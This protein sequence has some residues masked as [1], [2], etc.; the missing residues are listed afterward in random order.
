MGNSGELSV[1][2][3]DGTIATRTIQQVSSRVV[4][5]STPFTTLPA[6]GSIWVIETPDILT[7]TW[8]VVSITEGDQG[9]F[10]VTA[11]AYNASKFGYI[12][13]DV[14]LQRRDVTNLSAQ[15][16]APTNLVVTENLYEAGATVLVRVN[17]SFSPVQ[18]AAG[19]VVAYKAGEDNW[20]TLPETSSPEISLPDAPPG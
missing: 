8:R 14:P 6:V 9:V 10:Q 16:D 5:V 2:L 12:E 13:R 7:S 15:P 19:Y 11:L 17:L 18:R 20:I 1:I 3:P 4:M